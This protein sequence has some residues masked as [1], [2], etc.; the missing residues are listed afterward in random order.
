MKNSSGALMFRVSET[1][2][3]LTKVVGFDHAL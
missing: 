3:D 2:S 1:L